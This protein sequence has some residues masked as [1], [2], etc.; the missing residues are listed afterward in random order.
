MSATRRDL[1]A[2]W[3]AALFLAA[4]FIGGAFLWNGGHP[5]FP[6]DDAFIHLQ[7]A[8]ETSRLLLNPLKS[9]L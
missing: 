2:L 7:A 1:A 4:W 5:M 6:L 3:L 9:N 8:K